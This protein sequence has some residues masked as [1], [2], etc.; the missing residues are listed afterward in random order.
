MV[1]REGS[2]FA[3][4]GTRMGS[5]FTDYLKEAHRTLKLDDRIYIYEA[6]RSFIDKE[7]LIAGLRT[8]GFGQVAVEEEGKFTHIIASKTHTSPKNPIS[9]IDGLG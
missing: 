4:V 6:T 8:L 5:N 2:P 1:L 7:A 3:Q 9:S